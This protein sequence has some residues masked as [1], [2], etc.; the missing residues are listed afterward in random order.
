[1]MGV[2]LTDARIVDA[3]R[4]DEM[5]G[6]LVRLLKDLEVYR[7]TRNAQQEHEPED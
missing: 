2:S 5:P 1:M 7:K 3:M 6:D 4:K